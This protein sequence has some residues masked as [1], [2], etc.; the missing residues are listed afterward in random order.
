MARKLTVHAIGNTLLL[1]FKGRIFADAKGARTLTELLDQVSVE[2]E[3]VFTP[4][5][6]ALLKNSRLST[7][8]EVG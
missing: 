5:A 6:T 4:G 7:N 3:L 2:D 8:V 1:T